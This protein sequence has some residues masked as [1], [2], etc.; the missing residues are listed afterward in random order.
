MG[1]RRT[2]RKRRIIGTRSTREHKGAQRGK[3][4]K[5]DE[6]DKGQRGY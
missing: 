2:N 6:E 3:E 1:T 4:V 5:K